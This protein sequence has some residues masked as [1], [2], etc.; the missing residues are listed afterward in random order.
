MRRIVIEDAT[1]GAA[2]PTAEPSC[3][4][5]WLDLQ[6]WL[7]IGG[8]ASSLAAGAILWWPADLILIAVY[9]FAGVFM[10][11]KSKRVNGPAKP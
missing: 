7:L 4:E 8:V 3:A 1:P 9:C 6:D 11:E 5:R 10:I 2:E